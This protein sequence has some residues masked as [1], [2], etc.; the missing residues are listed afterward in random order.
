M[1]TIEK[2]WYYKNLPGTKYEDGKYYFMTRAIQICSSCDKL[3]I[4]TY[5]LYKDNK[6]QGIYKECPRCGFTEK[7]SIDEL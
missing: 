6:R 5:V 7:L 2:K 3:D 4:N 1:S